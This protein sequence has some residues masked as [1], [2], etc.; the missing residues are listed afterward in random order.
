MCLVVQR[1]PSRVITQTV[2]GAATSATTRA[3]SATPMFVVPKGTATSASYTGNQ[4]FRSRS[5]VR[6]SQARQLP[7]VD[8]LRIDGLIKIAQVRYPAAP[9]SQDTWLT[10]D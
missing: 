1:A 5:S 6:T 7:D 9:L 4:G 2:A 3:P 10:L 8:V